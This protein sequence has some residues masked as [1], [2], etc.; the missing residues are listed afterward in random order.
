MTAI[1][2]IPRT[3]YAVNGY[4]MI[5]L[6]QISSAAANETASLDAL[7][8]IVDEPSC[9]HA[10]VSDDDCGSA[11]KSWQ[12]PEEQ[13]C[14]TIGPSVIRVAPDQHLIAV[15]EVAM[16]PGGQYFAVGTISGVGDDMVQR[17]V[18][19]A[20]HGIKMQRRI[21]EQQGQINQYADQV[22]HDFAE[23]DWMQKLVAHLKVCSLSNS[24]LETAGGL[25]TPLRELIRAEAM[26]FVVADQQQDDNIPEHN[27]EAFPGIWIADDDNLQTVAFRLVQHYGTAARS[28]VVV[29]NRNV[30]WG[31]ADQFPGAT[32]FMLIAVHRDSRLTGWIVGVN[33]VYDAGTDNEYSMGANSMHTEAEFSTAE[34]GLLASAAS[35]LATHDH[36][37]RL[38]KGNIRLS[39]GI[40][41]ALANAVDAKDEYTRGHSDR[42]ARMAKHL[43][44]LLQLTGKE[45]QQLLM[46][47]LLHD[48]GKIGIPD[49][50]LQKDGRLTDEEFAVIQK[51][52]VF[53]FNILQPVA[54][55]KFVLPGVLHHHEAFDG[56]GYPEGLADS[57]IPL[58]ARILA[59]STLR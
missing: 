11:G 20:W 10:V 21:S 34:A 1:S 28:Q 37:V 52:P 58:V 2:R 59:I 38:L 16:I 32:G 57:D 50:V 14:G 53:G 7:R 45:C 22:L 36:N 3:V 18:S 54:E 8:L 6:K 44:S 39:I 24:L 9:G 42:V 55:L 17:L 4:T 56:S 49:N 33:R 41:R 27:D 13:F 5:I 30:V 46:T 12:F 47:G 23:I 48:I 26:G 31:E 35:I 51:H 40:I 25:I 19:S 43:G 29:R 15:P